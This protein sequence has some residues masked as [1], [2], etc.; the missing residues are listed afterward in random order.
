MS[1]ICRYWAVLR[2]QSV[3]P[4]T[5]VE[6]RDHETPAPRVL[7]A[8][9]SSIPVLPGPD[10]IK[11]ALA[12]LSHRYIARMGR[13]AVFLDASEDLD[14]WD[15]EAFFGPATSG[16]WTSR[17]SRAPWIRRTDITLPLRVVAAGPGAEA[18][19]DDLRTQ[20]WTQSEASQ[21]FGLQLH[22]TDRDTE[23]LVQA[24]QPHIVVTTAPHDV[25]AVAGRMTA[26]DRPRLVVWLDETFVTPAPAVAPGDV[27]GVALLRVGNP[28]GGPGRLITDICLEFTHDEPLHQLAEKLA[29]P[30]TRIRLTADP[31]SVQSLRLQPALG[32]IRREAQ[33]WETLFQALP[34]NSPLQSWINRT[35]K[36]EDFTGESH[37]FVP[38]AELRAS[39]EDARASVPTAEPSGKAPA[40]PGGAGDPKAAATRERAAHV[41][42]ERLDTHPY[43]KPVAPTTSLAADTSYQVRLHIGSPLADSLVEQPVAIDPHL[44]PPDDSAG[45]NLEVAIQGKAFA[46]E[47]ERAVKLRLPLAGNSDPIYFEVRT[48]AVFGPNELRL[49]IYH[50]NFLVQSLLLAALIEPSESDHTSRVTTVRVETTQAPN[51][52]ALYELGERA[53]SIGM[54]NG[55]GGKTHDF[56][57]TSDGKSNEISLPAT[58]FK[59]THDEIRKQLDAAARDPKAPK[60]PFNYPKIKPGSPTPTDVASWIRAFAAWGHKLYD[61]FFDRIAQ[62]GSPLRPQI[63]GLQTKTGER[64]QVFRFAYEDAF[65]W[66]LLYDWDLPSN[67]SAPVCLGWTLDALGNAVP[68]THHV[69]S[70]QYCVRG[71]WGVRH[72]IEELLPGTPAKTVQPPTGDKPV[73]LIADAGLR[74]SALLTTDLTTDL[75]AAALA[76]GP[77]QPASLLDVLFKT[78]TARPALLILLGHHERQLLPGGLG[79]S[80]IKIDSAPEWLSEADVRSRAQK[81]PTAW[82]QPRSTVV[83][84]ACASGTTGAETLTDF[85]TVWNACGASAIVG[86]EC[87]IGPQLAAEFARSFA[88]RVWKDKQNLGDAMAEIRAELLAEGNPL[89]FLFHSVGNIDLVLQ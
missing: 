77:V 25:L 14:A 29:H 49:C 71:F 55:S 57:L 56:V 85:T 60:L 12:N 84:M 27:S 6:Y 53:L 64:I 45:Y 59:T 79:Q 26:E 24:V 23:T 4:L 8:P 73:R 31:I 33:R 21:R 78:T 22:A 80:R 54:N 75:G 82:G 51:F 72:R 7:S 15:L 42:I 76:A 30:G 83:M 37:G 11:A 1:L 46:I 34:A 81:E 41:A 63:V 13:A 40:Y 19:F 17:L 16:W 89:A 20:G 43:L 38:I 52:S 48:P 44:G 2:L 28:T 36:I 5:V 62:T 32:Q 65:L 39:M 86:T 10:W 58:T 47:S 35:R 67:P 9:G 87:V 50:R 61:A 70:G 74:E 3:T 66:S 88:T 69:T 68:C 18:W